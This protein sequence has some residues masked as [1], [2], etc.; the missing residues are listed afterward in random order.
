MEYPYVLQ[1]WLQWTGCS[2]IQHLS[3]LRCFWRTKMWP[4]VLRYMRDVEFFLLIFRKWFL[5]WVKLVRKCQIREEGSIITVGL[6]F[7]SP[8]VSGCERECSVRRQGKCECGRQLGKGKWR[9]ADT[10]CGTLGG[11]LRTHTHPAHWSGKWRILRHMAVRFSAKTLRTQW[12][13][14]SRRERPESWS[15]DL[16][17]CHC[18]QWV[19]SE[20]PEVNDLQ[21]S[22]VFGIQDV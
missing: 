19:N 15:Q 14:D 1:L 12:R 6:F 8:K 11:K 5:N 7:L 20:F 3:D 10:K 18:L 2:L 21:I 4:C 17:C 13:I 16:R 22:W 9:E